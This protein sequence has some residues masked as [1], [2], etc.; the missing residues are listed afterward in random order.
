MND[1][2][3]ATSLPDP[4]GSFNE[5]ACFVLQTSR[6][7][8]PLGSKLE[9]LNFVLSRSESL[10]AEQSLEFWDNQPSKKKHLRRALVFFRLMSL[11][12]RYPRPGAPCVVYLTESHFLDDGLRPPS[13]IPPETKFS[14]CYTR[15][16]E[17]FEYRGHYLITDSKFNPFFVKRRLLLV[18]SNGTRKDE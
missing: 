1:F 3:L 8:V 14:W 6:K 11:V 10:T 5:A 13:C 9:W 18:L 2:E 4:S 15:D 17:V 7:D 12:K 16:K